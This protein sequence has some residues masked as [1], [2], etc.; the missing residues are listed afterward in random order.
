MLQV[1]DLEAVLRGFVKE[2][3]IPQIF[4]E[5]PR[6]LCTDAEQLKATYGRCFGAQLASGGTHAAFLAIDCDRIV[7]IHRVMKLKKRWRWMG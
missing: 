6:M 7:R 4:R 2:D 3:E 1:A 5:E